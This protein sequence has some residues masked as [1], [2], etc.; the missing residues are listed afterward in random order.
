MEKCRFLSEKGICQIGQLAFHTVDQALDFPDLTT[1]VC[2]DVQVP[3]KT[4]LKTGIVELGNTSVFKTFFVMDCLAVNDVT[5]Q[6]SC[7][8]FLP[9]KKDKRAEWIE[10]FSEGKS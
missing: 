3:N 10:N 5:E 8:T 9:K 4:S 1:L 6:Q 2:G 7:D